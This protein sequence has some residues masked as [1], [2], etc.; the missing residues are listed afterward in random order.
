MYVLIVTS[1]YASQLAFHNAINRYTFMLARDGVL[2]PGSA[3][4][5]RS[6]RPYRAGS[7]QTVLA[8]VVI[9]VFAVARR[10]PVQA[11]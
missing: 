8:V 3:G 2:P 1:V 9:A 10:R 4:P 11:C 7:V 5:P 6:A